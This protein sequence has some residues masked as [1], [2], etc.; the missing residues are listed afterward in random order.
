MYSL[1]CTLPES[2][3]IDTLLNVLNTIQPL[4]MHVKY[5]KI[6]PLNRTHGWKGTV[7][8]IAGP[9]IKNKL[10]TRRISIKRYFFKTR[11]LGFME[12]PNFLPTSTPGVVRATI[13]ASSHMPVQLNPEPR[14]SRF[15]W[16]D[17]F[18]LCFVRVW[19]IHVPPT[20]DYASGA[21]AVDTLQLGSGP[22]PR[23]HLSSYW[24]GIAKY[25]C[26]HACCKR[27]VLMQISANDVS[28]KLPKR[29]RFLSLG[30]LIR[31]YPNMMKPLWNKVIP[32]I[33][34]SNKPLRKHSGQK[35]ELQHLMEQEVIR[36][37]GY[38]S[39]CSRSHE[40]TVTHKT[41]GSIQQHWHQY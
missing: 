23:A 18:R 17:A 37:F 13:Q 24:W 20:P 31:H 7:F 11:F 19:P 25:Y 30:T 1:L 39:C 41:F 29:T 21:C 12:L 16:K 4:F 36:V 5:Y 35:S 22:G 40:N 6:Q 27:T 38:I 32:N 3:D 14:Q 10:T 34:E 8:F 28:R 2:F 15:Q 9:R 33:S 26:I